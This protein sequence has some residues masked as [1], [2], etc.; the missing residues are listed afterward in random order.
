MR[1]R[2]VLIPAIAVLI[3]VGLSTGGRA[4][5]RKPSFCLSCHEMERPG[6]G[7]EVSGAKEDHQ[8]CIMCHSGPGPLGVVEAQVRGLQMIVAHFVKSEEDLKGPFKSKMPER[9]CTQCHDPVKIEGPHRKLPMEGRECRDCHKHSEDWE[10]HG[11][12][13]PMKSQTTQSDEGNVR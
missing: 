12:V 13:R 3:G 5:E 1:W 6:K 7:W 4:L 9:F 8:D 10:F 2:W 11:E